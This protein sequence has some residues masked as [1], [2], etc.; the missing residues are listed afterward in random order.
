MPS[1]DPLPSSYLEG[2]ML[3]VDKPKGWTSFD[4]VNKVRYRLKQLLGVKKIKVGHA[5]TL[6]PLA[7]GLLILCTGKATKNI[8]TFQGLPKYYEGTLILGG[9][10][11]SYDAETEVDAEFPYKH[12][13]PRQLQEAAA[14]LTGDISQIPPMFSAIKVDGQPLYK[15]ARKGIVLEVKARE[16]QIH[17]FELTRIEL[18][19]VD[20]KVHCSKGTYIRSLAHDLGASLNSGAYLSALRRTAIGPY[21][22]SEAWQLDDLVESLT[23]SS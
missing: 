1:D 7:T 14:A 20:F 23:V 12:I 5:G 10:T 6:D 4:V 3:L 15:K 11:P 22:I 21:N 17:E 8:D 9:T 2:R 13:T 18:P 19:E 16:V